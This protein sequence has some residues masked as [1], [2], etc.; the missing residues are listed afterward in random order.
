MQ[1]GFAM[2]TEKRLELSMIQQKLENVKSSLEC[3][4]NIK[5]DISCDE[6]SRSAEEQLEMRNQCRIIHQ[7]AWV[8]VYDLNVLYILFSLFA[9]YICFIF[10][11]LGVE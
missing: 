10:S 4:C 3:F 7:Q 11:A 6:V 8:L 5:G 2:I 9:T 1:D